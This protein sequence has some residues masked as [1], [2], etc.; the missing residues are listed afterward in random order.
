[1]DLVT[2]GDAA[3]QLGINASALRYYEERGLVRPA[4]RRGGRRMYGP[5][6]LRRV[7]FIQV[8]RQL[9]ISLDAAAAM[10][11]EPG[12]QWRQVVRGQVDLLEQLIAQATGARDFLVHALSCPARHPVGECSYL[13]EVLDRRVAGASLEQL[14]AE[15]GYTGPLRPSR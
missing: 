2:I 14:A 7:A 8:L 9:G 10:L 12:D 4:T 6:Q 5:E 1:M 13:T 11:D 3:G 15:H